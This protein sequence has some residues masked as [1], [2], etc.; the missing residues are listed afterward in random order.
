MT[1]RVDHLHFQLAN[2]DD[3]AILQDHVLANLAQPMG[4]DLGAGFVRKA[5]VVEHVIP[6]MVGIE[7]Q[8]DR[9]AV[10]LRDFL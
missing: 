9:V 3:A 2:V 5:L 4:G 10:L 8:L 1:G 7:N 6:V